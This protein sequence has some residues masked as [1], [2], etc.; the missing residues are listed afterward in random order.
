[1][2][3]STFQ[4]KTINC[5]FN[6]SQKRVFYITINHMVKNIDMPSPGEELFRG[7]SQQSTSTSYPH[8]DM[9]TLVKTLKR[10]NN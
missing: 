6:V 5:S 4:F 10:Y 7:V 1:M 8:P 2:S 3:S 9:L